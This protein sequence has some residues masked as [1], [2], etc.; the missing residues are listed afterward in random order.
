MQIK[1]VIPNILTISRILITPIIIFLGINKH[2]EVLAIICVIIALTDCFDGKLARHWGVCSEFGAKLD[3]IG[4]KFLAISLLSMLIINKKE[5]LYL[6]IIETLIAIIN[7]II[8]L[9]SRSSNSLLIGKI[10]TWILY[11][12]LILGVINLFFSKIHGIVDIGILLSFIFQLLTLLSYINF[13]YL[14]ITKKKD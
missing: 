8:Y 13:Y 14:L 5:F 4:D 7:L 12:T 10:K 11:I 2:Y 6:L 3:T 1:K 9:K